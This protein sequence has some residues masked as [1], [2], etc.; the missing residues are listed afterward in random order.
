MRP[1]RVQ[2]A[3]HLPLEPHHDDRGTF[4]EW[5]RAEPVE[6]ASGRRLPL[7]QAN[8]SVSRRGVV[9]GVHFVDVPPGQA[10]YVTCVAGT[11][12]DVVVDV[13]VGSPTYGQWDSVLLGDGRWDAVY[14]PEGLGHAF[15]ALSDSATVM[16]LCSTPYVAGRERAVDP[17][18]PELRL[19]WPEDVPA[20]VSAKDTNAPSLEQAR[21]AGLLP[22]YSDSATAAGRAP[23]TPARDPVTTSTYSVERQRSRT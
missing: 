19:P 1:L 22:I 11:V 6:E 21:R 13:R 23:G 7:A 16:Y 10:K 18:D 2:D 17:F 5:Y 15:M 9:R 4:V 8:C 12:L 14:L 3:W 20:V